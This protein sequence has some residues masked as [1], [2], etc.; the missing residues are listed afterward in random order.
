M[1]ITKKKKK[2]I[3]LKKETRGVTQSGLRG[4]KNIGE[5]IF[6]FLNSSERI[7]DVK[8]GSPKN[9]FEDF[10]FSVCGVVQHYQC[11]STQ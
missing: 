8:K 1:L 4:E 11:I 9:G 7:D 2:K 10:S 5:K 6:F 3:L